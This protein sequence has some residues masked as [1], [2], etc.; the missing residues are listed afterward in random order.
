MRVVVDG[1]ALCYPLTGIGQYTHSLLSALARQR[2]AWEFFLVTPY[3]AKQV[4][5]HPNLHYSITLSR[6]HTSHNYGWRAW[7]FDSILPGIVHA[8]QPD[9]FW[10]ASGLAPFGLVGTPVALTVYDF[11]AER[12]PKTMSPLARVY[13]KWN[14]R[15]WLSRSRWLF[16]IS[17]AVARESRERSRREIA[18]VVYPGIDRIFLD[19]GRSV[20]SSPEFPSDYLLVLGT[21]EPR[22]NLKNLFQA[23]RILIA[24]GSWPKEKKLIIVG[25]K[26]WQDASISDDVKKLSALDVARRLGY[27]SRESLPGIFAG[28]QALLMPSL[29][30]GFGMPVAEALAVGCPV[31]CSDIPSFR[32]IVG[33]CNAAASFHRTD[34]LSMVDAYRRLVVEPSRYLRRCALG[35]LPFRWE[36][37]AH[38][39]AAAIES[40]CTGID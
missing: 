2:P 34:L 36:Q 22:K 40:T 31:V 35:P 9:F 39:F 23:V 29:Y 1:T 16:P 5:K 38:D 17:E 25:A 3:F 28:A 19:Y 15:F 26:G 12:Y 10:A 18:A 24:E 7:W 6:A 13:R 14:Q 8:L 30:E 33:N 11:V 37:S 20:K 21:L 32:E 4:P 27:I